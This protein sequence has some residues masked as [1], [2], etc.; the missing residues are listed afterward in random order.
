MQFLG[1]KSNCKKPCSSASEMSR[2]V[3]VI[4][5]PTGPELESFYKSIAQAKDK[6][7]I[8][9]I[10]QPF[11]ESFVPQLSLPTIPQPITQLYN[12][13]TLEMGYHDLLKECERVFHTIEVKKCNTS[14]ICFYC[15]L[16]TCNI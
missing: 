8:L 6:P 1:P 3:K 15:I 13:A 2:N 4:P 14:I 7:A 11:A 16:C 12:P 10:T 5:P 9:K